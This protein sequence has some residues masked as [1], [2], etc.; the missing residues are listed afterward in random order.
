MT[1]DWKIQVAVL[2]PLLLAASVCASA[3]IL[4]R[5]VLS[6]SRKEASERKLVLAEKVYEGLSAEM[7]ALS[8]IGKAVS[9]DILLQGVLGDENKNH[10]VARELGDYLGTL[11]ETSHLSSAFIVSARTGCL[12]D[13][14][15]QVRNLDTGEGGRDAWYDAL[16]QSSGGGIFIAVSDNAKEGKKTLL[17][18]SL[19]TDGAGDIL[20]AAG[21]GAGLSAL[22]SVLSRNEQQSGCRAVLIDEMGMVQVSAMGDGEGDYLMDM[23]LNLADS[24]AYTYTPVGKR[25]FS[26][27]KRMAALGWYLLVS[28][29][30]SPHA[31]ALPPVIRLLLAGMCLCVLSALAF[32]HSIRK[33]TLQDGLEQTEDSLTGL[34]NRNYFREAYGEDSYFN[35]MSYKSLAVIDVDS[36][37]SVEGGKERETVLRGIVSDLK[38]CFSDK[39]LCMRWSRDCFVLFSELGTDET[40]ALCQ[41]VCDAALARTGSSLSVGVAEISL[42]ESIKKNYYR[43]MIACFQVKK[44]GGNGVLGV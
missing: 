6:T 41:R 40:L 34:P 39:C 13:C 33:F 3:A 14:T 15:G 43:A 35:T 16:I 24:D 22:R 30:G 28:G 21:I 36:F 2:L 10:D 5:G 4:L 11:K 17:S 8:C 37:S 44:D 19:I 26:V 20:G 18:C 32:C 12:Y 25:G 27:T 31:D 23:K 7:Q 42:T 29:V 9:S 38:D 1:K